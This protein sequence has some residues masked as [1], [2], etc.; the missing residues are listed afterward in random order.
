MTSEPVRLAVVGTSGIGQLHARLAAADADVQLVGLSGL[1]EGAPE[2]AERLGVPLHTDFRE[3]A[4][5]GLDGAII[6]TPNRMHLE[7]A[8]FFAGRGVHILVEKPIAD[9]LAAGREICDVAVRC[10]V[11]L[12]VGHQRRHNHLVRTAAELVERDL[13]RLVATTTMILMKKPDSYY[14]EGWRRTAS[15]GP[16]L[17]NLIHDIDL[18]R[19]VC[20]EV[21]RVQAAASRHVRGFDFDD[22][23][24]VLL[25]FRNGALGTV[26]IAESVP[27]PWSWEFSVAEGL[28]FPISGQDHAYFA[29][30]E[31]SLAFP[32][33]TLWSYHSSDEGTGWRS[34]IHRRQ[35]EV[36]RNDPYAAQVAH[37][38]AVIRGVEV[39]RVSG[40]EALRSL[41]VVA[42]VMEA[43]RTGGVVD[44]DDVLDRA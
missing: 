6:A 26:T 8:A 11:H 10:G 40:E 1:D 25:H 24:M 32:S 33:M 4:D 17:I 16:L 12:L 37:F 30:T 22:T 13:G 35:V 2:V 28:D 5:L 29:G 14:R 3:L 9:T 18:L 31:A 27:S 42:A 7:M 36:A 19:A 39:P 21:D 38:A 41:A 15:A 43:V 34:P 23:A 44:V 20:G